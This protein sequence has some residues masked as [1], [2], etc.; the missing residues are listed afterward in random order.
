MEVENLEVVVV[1]DYVGLIPEDDPT[2]NESVII[3]AIIVL[4]FPF[5]F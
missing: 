2:M 1:A 3:I 5:F 4:L